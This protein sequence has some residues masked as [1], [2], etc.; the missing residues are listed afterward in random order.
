MLLLY[1]IWFAYFLLT[2]YGVLFYCFG[3]DVALF[4][5]VRALKQFENEDAISTRRRNGII[6][7]Q[8]PKV[9]FRRRMYYFIAM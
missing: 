2:T 4:V 8:I 9:G 7:T 5:V 6:Q 1:E 3:S